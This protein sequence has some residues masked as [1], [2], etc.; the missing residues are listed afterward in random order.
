V[1]QSGA[2]TRIAPA[3]FVLFFNVQSS[4]LSADA[5]SIVRAAVDA[6]QR[7]HAKQIELTAL[8][9]KDE[10]AHDPLL[11]SRRA[12]SVK[13]EIAQLGFTSAVVTGGGQAPG[14]L[15]V[16]NGS[17]DTVNRRVVISMRP[18]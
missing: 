15:S 17:D 7:A 14:L 4:K 5:K 13:A 11:A 18:G 9:A 6:A 1:P 3:N 8:S 2:A 10:T 12:A 16:S